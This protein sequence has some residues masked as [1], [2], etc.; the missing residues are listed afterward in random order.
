MQS[1]EAVR[2]SAW[3]IPFFSCEISLQGDIP[4]N[5]QEACVHG[6]WKSVLHPIIEETVLLYSDP[7]ISSWLAVQPEYLRLVFPQLV[8]RIV[9]VP[10]KECADNGVESFPIYA[11]H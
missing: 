3:Y 8:V 9:C 2:C 6:R 4:K 1:W 11:F 5:L 7:A 10:A